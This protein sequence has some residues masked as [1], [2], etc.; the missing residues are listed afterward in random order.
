[1]R[2]VALL[3][4]ALC[5]A[6]QIQSRS[7]DF[8]CDGPE[9]CSGGR[10][11]VDGWCIGGGGDIDAGGPDGQQC[12]PPCTTCDN[13]TCVIRCEGLLSCPGTI[14]CP[15]GMACVVDCI[16]ERSCNGGISCG[17]A[18]ECTINC[19]GSRSCAGSITCGENAC[20]IGCNADRTCS[21]AFDC[22]LACACDIGCTG[23]QSCD[24]T[25][26]CPTGGACTLGVGCTSTAAGCDTCP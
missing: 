18:T 23:P 21:A 24:A 11:C 3:F 1:M 22:S 13:N 15:P 10:T 16:G 20:T 12:D 9:D 6:C 17:D 5:A 14:L 25:F 4:V 19:D 26:L 8:R 7:D 2:L